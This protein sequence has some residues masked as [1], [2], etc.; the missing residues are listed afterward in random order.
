MNIELNREQP[1][2]NEVE[3]KGWKYTED[4]EYHIASRECSVCKQNFSVYIAKNAG[5]TLDKIIA[6]DPSLKKIL[7]DGKCSYCRK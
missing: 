1:P 4:A 6:N 7:T 2:K 5:K 3:A